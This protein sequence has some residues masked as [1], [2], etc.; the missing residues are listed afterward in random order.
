M[1]VNKDEFVNLYNQCEER[2]RI[3]QQVAGEGAHIGEMQNRWDNFDVA[4]N[5]FSSMIDEQ[6]NVLKQETDKRIGALNMELEKTFNRWEALKPKETT[7]MDRET[8]I[9]TSEKMKEWREK[10]EELETKVKNIRDDCMHFG[11]EE[12]N[13]NYYEELKS[14]L[15]QQQEG[16]MF[17]DEFYKELE[18]LGKEDWLSFSRGK[19]IYQFQD[20][21][22]R[23]EEKIKEKKASIEP[24]TKQPIVLRLLRQAI[25]HFKEAWPLFKICVGEAFEKEHW[26]ALFYMLTFPKEVTVENLKFGNFLDHIE[27]MVEKSS[28]IK[29]LGARA[30]GEISIREAIQELRAWCDETE[31]ALTQYEG[32]N[33][34]T[35]PLIKD[36]KDLMNSVSD[37]QSLLASLKESRFF[38][39]FAD[40]VD[41]FESKLTG[42]DEYLQ[43]LNVIQRK[44]V[45]LEPIFIRGALPAE[46]ARFNRVDGEYVSIMMGIG[47]NPKVIALCDIGGLKETLDTILSQLDVCQ[48]ALNDFLEEKRSKFPRFYFIGDDDL[49]EILGQATNPVVIQTHL[50]KLFAGIF[51]VD[52]NQDNSAIVTMLSSAGEVVDLSSPV[53]ITEDVEIWLGDLVNEMRQTLSISLKKA[54]NS[55]DVDLMNTP[56]QICCLAEMVHF[57][58]N[59]ASAI[60][61]GKLSNYKIDLQKNLEMYTSTDHKGDMLLLSKLKALTLDIIH[62]IEVID[63]LIDTGVKNISQWGWYKQLKYGLETRRDVTTVGMCDAIFDYTFEYQGNAPKLVHTPLTDK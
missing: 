19:G 28:D 49:L 32:G 56:S 63:V 35:V 50:K 34:R 29:D 46:Q 40:S 58:N 23:W 62:N 39:R 15:A 1:L 54:L 36:W 16:W 18:E 27:V 60:K 5:A 41:Q 51:K 26:R 37:N 7:E 42:I 14:D 47:M 25:D 55:P 43:K 30:Q 20:F 59:T 33:N 61:K 38:S 22:D 44:W 3:L 12:P 2:N 13:L 10:W 6:K 11:I 45:Y 8:A 4:L 17:Y 24:G 21:M 9:E 57:S 52:F 48:K 31:F 53:Q